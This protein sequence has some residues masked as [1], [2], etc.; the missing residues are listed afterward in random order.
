M[1]RYKSNSTIRS[2]PKLR[3]RFTVLG[4]Q[5]LADLR[6][7]IFCHCSQG[8]FYDISEDPNQQPMLASDKPFDH[9]FFF[10]NDTFYN[11]TRQ[12]TCDYSENIRVWAEARENIGEFKVDSMES[13][14]FGQLEVRLGSPCLY[15][16]HGN[17]E[18]VFTFS[19]LRLV[20]SGDS[21]KRKDYPLLDL[22]TLPKAVCCMTCGDTAARVVFD[23]TIH[24]HD[25]TFLCVN[26]FQSFHY[27]NG[28]KVG[29]FRAYRFKGHDE[30]PLSGN[31]SSN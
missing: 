4:S 11:D 16:H 21:L 30:V 6:D 8:P 25:P 12:L 29:E 18:H 24:L 10:I 26:C 17:C 22:I 9:G 27:V 7:R 3:Q 14:T 2:K 23:S 15:Q 19:D 13:T 5:T 31:L 28:Q 1:C 20:A